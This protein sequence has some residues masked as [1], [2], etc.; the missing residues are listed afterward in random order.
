LC[1]F[2]VGVLE[3]AEAEKVPE[4]S[5]R[6]RSQGVDKGPARDECE[7]CLRKE[8]R[9]WEAAGSPK[10]GWKPKHIYKKEALDHWQKR[11]LTNRDFDDLWAEVFPELKGNRGK[12]GW[13]S[14]NDNHQWISDT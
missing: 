13:R 1:F 8:R 14:E 9:R 12:S 10:K 3:A 6:R 7:T 4:F 11:G 2:N 5:Y